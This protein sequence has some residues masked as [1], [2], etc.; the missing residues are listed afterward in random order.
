MGWNFKKVGRFY[1]YELD[2]PKPLN[3]WETYI[4]LSLIVVFVL[5]VGVTVDLFF[6][7]FFVA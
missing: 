7:I 5:I 4:L 3:F 6:G 1:E 2:K